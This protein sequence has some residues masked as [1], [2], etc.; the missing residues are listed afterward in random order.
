MKEKYFEELIGLKV[1][2][3]VTGSFCTIREVLQEIESLVESGADVYPILSFSTGNMDTRFIGAEELKCRL[4][5][6]TGNNVITTIQ[7]AEPIGPKKLLDVMVVMPCT[8]NTM[9]KLANSV[10]DSPALMAVKSHLRNNRPVVLAVSTNDGLMG[11]AV[12]IGK[13]LARKN[14]Y[15]VPFGQDDCINKPFSL[16]ADFTKICETVKEAAEGKQLQPLL[17]KEDK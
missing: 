5:E 14:I 3:A 4:K 17:L 11:S 13:M 12:N 1:G 8:G 9:A 16:V 10:V 15:F 7:E 2:V 6:I